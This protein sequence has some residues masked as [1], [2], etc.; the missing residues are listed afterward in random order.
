MNQTKVNQSHL[1]GVIRISV[2]IFLAELAIMLA[3]LQQSS[4]NPW[5]ATLLDATLVT[6]ITFYFSYYLV[7]SKIEISQP[8]AVALPKNRFIHTFSDK[9]I[10]AAKLALVIF[11]VECAIMLIIPFF[12]LEHSQTEAVIDSVL[13]TII[14]GPLSYY[15]ITGTLQLPKLL[16]LG[17]RPQ[18]SIFTLMFVPS[19][20]V[21]ALLLM[22]IF[23]SEYVSRQQL[24]Q[25]GTKHNLVMMSEN[26]NEFLRP[27]ILD[28]QHLGKE[29][30]MQ[31]F[32][33]GDHWAK[34]ALTNDYL[35]MLNINPQFLQIR[36]LDLDGKEIIRVHRTQEP[37]IVPEHELQQKKQR[38]YFQ[39]SVELGPDSIYISGL[40]LNI[41]HGR[42]EIP[43]KPVIRIATPVYD[44]LGSKRG[45]LVV[46]ISGKMFIN[47]LAENWL[48]ITGETIILLN[49][50]GYWL[51]GPDKEDLW[52]FHFPDKKERTFGNKFPD[53]WSTIHTRHS[54]QI[55][56][57]LG[58][59]TFNT[60][61]FDKSNFRKMVTPHDSAEDHGKS[62]NHEHTTVSDTNIK[63]HAPEMKLVSMISLS[64]DKMEF[65]DFKRNF[66][67][68]M[69]FL[70]A[71]VAMV[72]W[73]LTKAI[74][75][76]RE[77]EMELVQH[78]ETLEV[79]IEKRTK[80][81]AHADRLASLGT[82]SAGMAHEIN[83]PNSF[84]A[85]NIDFLQLFW[86]IARPILEKNRQQDS[87]GRLEASL[88]DVDET[89]AGMKEGSDRIT[90][91]VESLKAY[92]R[93][94][95]ESDKVECRLADPLQDAKYLLQHRIKKGF[96]IFT[97][98]P[99][100]IVIVCDRQQMSQVF[101]NLLNN[102]M[103]ALETVKEDKKKLLTITA[104]RV[105]QHVWIKVCDNGPGIP[106]EV[107]GKIFDPFYTSKGK[108]KGTGLG[109]S[110]VHGIIEDHAGQITVNASQNNGE[111]TEFLIILP[112]MEHYKE[113][114]KTGKVAANITKQRAL[115]VGNGQK[116]KN[117]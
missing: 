11:T 45:V 54:G 28:V 101:I 64:S 69:I 47:K 30:I 60:I 33:E 114:V 40:D 57:Q 112:S 25:V 42:V 85:G 49:S 39:E 2:I 9:L 82:F 84:I 109:L 18:A 115:A 59:T 34:E 91:I 86:S 89:L 50:D 5:L 96:S 93:G 110:I 76:R 113:L 41:E 103:D 6:L 38:H 23:H 78:A 88:G 10:I 90:R 16:T 68:L 106:Q 46:N 65:N 31:R 32:L 63:F 61:R 56:S 14:S 92:S 51:Y 12:N 21:I 81:L 77:A 100:E 87:S 7:F 108:T 104:E 117:K 79:T 70:T 105:D 53:L 8:T 20:I 62:S 4:F 27:T 35:L 29:Y 80:Q 1:T 94:G 43:F 97:A 75:R 74:H 55:E 73:N 26:L 107:V 44:R 66:I 99:D 111:D 13:L 48:H 72:L 83:N 3:F 22:A 116:A 15:W 24:L 95:M 37:E 71:L 36:Y 17:N 52:G 102:S 19:F 67:I 58:L 98:I